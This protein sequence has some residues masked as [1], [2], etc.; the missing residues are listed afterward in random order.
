[1]KK[2]TETGW[3]RIARHV[4]VRERG[5]GAWIGVKRR[6]REGRSTGGI[7]TTVSRVRLTLYRL[8]YMSF[9]SRS[10]RNR[11]RRQDYSSKEGVIPAQK[12]LPRPIGP[13]MRGVA[14]RFKNPHRDPTGAGRTVIYSRCVRASTSLIP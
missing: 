13:Y 7:P 12:T 2:E 8:Q 1:M 3:G 14:A 6:G 11:R 4:T 10:S 5:T 9:P